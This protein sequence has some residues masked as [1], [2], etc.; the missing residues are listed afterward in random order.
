[1]SPDKIKNHYD[2]VVKYLDDAIDILD[3][4][5]K[6]RMPKKTEVSYFEYSQRTD[7]VV[8]S[9]S[10]FDDMYWQQQYYNAIMRSG[11]NHHFRSI[12]REKG[13]TVE[14]NE[15]ESKYK[16]NTKDLKEQ[17]KENNSVIIDRINNDPVDSLT[18]GEKKVKS[19]MEKRADILH[20]NI[21]NEKYRNELSDDR[22]FTTHLNICSLL[23]TN[24]DTK[25][26]DKSYKELKVQNA[27]S[28]TTK[29]KLIDEVQKLMNVS[30][31]CINDINDEAVIPDNT[32][33]VI[34]KVFRLKDVNLIS[35]YRNLVP[36]IMKS[37]RIMTNGVRDKVYEIDTDVLRHH[38]DL[39]SLRNNKMNGIYADTLSYYGYTPPKQKKMF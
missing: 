11:M 12:L 10:I 17:I 23:N 9:T 7:E 5:N 37:K 31:L 18:A 36:G 32:Q 20:L 30:P 29:L 6:D 3:P 15:E 16:I 39:L 21:D 4:I 24:I 14:V 1:M 25:F 26:I 22:H 2:D 8:I 27:K 38:L 34:K 33:E 28:N 35:M 13:Y 19:A